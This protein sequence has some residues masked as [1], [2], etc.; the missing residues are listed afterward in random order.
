MKRVLWSL[1]PSYFQKEIL[2]FSKTKNTEYLFPPGD[3]RPGHLPNMWSHLCLSKGA[4]SPPGWGWTLSDIQLSCDEKAMQVL[5]GQFAIL[6]ATISYLFSTFISSSAF[7]LRFIKGTTWSTLQQTSPRLHY[8]QLSN[9][10][11][12]NIASFLEILAG[13]VKRLH[14]T[15]RGRGQ[16]WR[17]GGFS[18]LRVILDLT[19]TF[20]WH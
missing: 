5:A 15:N 20:S 2:I 4:G 10:T 8:D 1:R 9:Q 6:W 13:F 19:I 17:L 12:R 11:L 16:L 3:S 14:G 18:S 7:S